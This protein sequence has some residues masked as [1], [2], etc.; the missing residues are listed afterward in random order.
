MGMHGNIQRC[1]AVKTL[2]VYRN[3]MVQIFPHYL[4]IS[5]NILSIHG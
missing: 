1:Q 3:I 4:R 5:F 2:G